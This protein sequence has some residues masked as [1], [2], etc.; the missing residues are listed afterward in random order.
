MK[1]GEI[2]HGFKLVYSQPMPDLKAT[3]HRFTY[4]KNGADVI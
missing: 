1:P 3:L 4:W 2:L